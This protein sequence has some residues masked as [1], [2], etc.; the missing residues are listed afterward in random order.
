MV[1]TT[2]LT[3]DVQCPSRARR[4]L[5][6]HRPTSPESHLAMF[7][8]GPMELLVVAVIALVVLGPQ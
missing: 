5:A 7:N 4:T 2:G 3:D 6:T 1:G 8:L